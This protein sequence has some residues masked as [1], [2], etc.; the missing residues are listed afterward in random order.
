MKHVLND[1]PVFSS[2]GQWVKHLKGVLNDFTFMKLL[3][4]LVYGKD[5]SFDVQS[6]KAFKS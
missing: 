1:L 4:Y 3:I 5:K 6:L 2:I